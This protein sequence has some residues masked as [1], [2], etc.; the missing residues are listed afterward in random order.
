VGLRHGCLRRPDRDRRPDG[1]LRVRVA[2]RVDR[3]RARSGEAEAGAGA[4][5]RAGADARAARRRAQGQGDEHPTAE[6]ARAGQAVGPRALAGDRRRDRAGRRLLEGR[7]RPDP[8]DG[9]EGEG[10]RGVMTAVVPRKKD[11]E[12]EPVTPAREI[13]LRLAKPFPGPRRMAAVALWWLRVGARIVPWIPTM[14]LAEIRPIFRGF[15]RLSVGWARW[16]SCSDLAEAIRSADG[17][18]RSKAAERYEKRKSAR[19]WGSLRSEEH[20]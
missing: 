7:R 11:Y 10:G 1:D 20:T 19:I 4:E 13:A 18:E 8:R 6:Q 14:V 17:N 16:A 2:V 12:V 3:R 5:A 9:E 15:G